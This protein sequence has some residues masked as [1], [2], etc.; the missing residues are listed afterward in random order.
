M[1]SVSSSSACPMHAAAPANAPALHP[2]GHWP[3]GPPSGVTGWGLLNRMSRDLM[4]TL[5]DW[6]QCHGDL[7]HLRI[8]PEHQ[9]VVTDP[10]LVRE[11]LVANHDALIRWERGMRVFSQVHGHSVLVSEGEAW[12]DKRHALQPAFSPKSTQSFVPTIAETA[13]LAMRVWPRGDNAQWPIESALTTL[14]MDVIVRMLFSRPIGDDA[15]SVAQAVHTVGMAAD[16]EFY[17]PASWPDAMPWKRAKREA[18]ALLRTLIDGHLRARSA[19]APQERPDDLLTRLLQ[20]HH[21]D[22]AAWP[23]Q[24]VHDECM[25]AFL[26]GHETVAATL[27]WWAWCLASNP[28]AQRVAADEVKE[29]LQGRAPTAQDLT[30]LPALTRTLQETMRLYPAAPVLFSRRATRP[31]TLGGWQFPARTMFMVPVQLMQR[32]PRWFADP[33]VFRPERFAP[34]APEVPRG[35]YMP[36]GAGPR[37]CLGQHLAMTE[38]TV[39]AAMLLQRHVLSVPEGQGAPRPMLNVTLR[40]ASPLHLRVSPAG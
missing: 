15:A 14:A 9:V 7:V 6:R 12:R 17:W 37:V 13:E 40:P 31:V 3:P 23:L 16:S 25:T 18:K 4:G 1:N 29:R 28:E 39:V 32:D 10:A 26:A 19:M 33:L 35:A 8:W 21:D 30:A 20:L 2:L 5:G 27:T 22:P 34:G 36:L 38:M 24:A 11:L